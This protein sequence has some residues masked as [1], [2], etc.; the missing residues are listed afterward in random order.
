MKLYYFL[1]VIIL[2]CILNDN[3]LY[4]YYDTAHDATHTYITTQNK[5]FIEQLIDKVK[6]VIP[7]YGTP[8]INTDQL[9]VSGG[10]QNCAQYTNSCGLYTGDQC[11]ECL[12]C[13]DN[14][15]FIDSYYT[16]MCKSIEHCIHDKAN[17]D[18][19]INAYNYAYNRAD[20]SGEC[21]SSNLTDA[22]N[23]TCTIFNDNEVLDTLTLMV[24]DDFVDC[25]ATVEAEEL[26]S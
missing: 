20:W 3:K 14:N 25:V 5:S 13:I 10:N 11:K 24:A 1:V 12:K 4:E 22:Q 23:T 9:S 2:I 18:K 6:S 15:S 8:D 19:N 17:Y 26:F 7:G 21:A 16:H